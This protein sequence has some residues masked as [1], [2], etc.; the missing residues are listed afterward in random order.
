MIERAK[1]AHVAPQAYD[2]MRGLRNYVDS[3]SLEES[4]LEL[5]KP[6]ASYINGC[7][8]CIDM[9]AKDTRVIGDVESAGHSFQSDVGS[10][11]PAG[12]D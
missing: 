11:Q 1:V 5:A 2:A 9:H 12:H 6:S 8:Y 4:L 3:S 7:A 10:Y